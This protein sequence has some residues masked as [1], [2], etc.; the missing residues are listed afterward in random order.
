[1]SYLFLQACGM[2]NALLL[3]WPSFECLPCRMAADTRRKTECHCEIYSACLPRFCCVELR[4][5]IL[6]T[7]LWAASGWTWFI[8]KEFH[9]T[10]L[11]ATPVRDKRYAHGVL[12]VRYCNGLF[13]INL[14]S[15]R[16][17]FPFTLT[18]FVK[19]K[20]CNRS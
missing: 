10:K 3:N 17:G 6:V 2:G 9:P 8:A 15:C 14:R 4:V 5:E 7:S 11:P 18:S 13:A 12:P 20:D 16:F 19:A 1:M